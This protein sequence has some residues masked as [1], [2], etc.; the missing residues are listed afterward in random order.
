MRPELQQIEHIL[1]SEVRPQLREHGG[2]LSVDRLENGVL[3]IK[4]MGQ[5]AGCPSADLTTE[6][7]VEDAL[8]KAL[9]ELVQRVVCVQEVSDELWEQAKRILRGEKP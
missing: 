7:V 9:P 2:N 5:C 8:V 3:Y 4:M 6:T 1:D